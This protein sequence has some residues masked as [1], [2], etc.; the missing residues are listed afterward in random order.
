M[1]ARGASAFID[2]HDRRVVFFSVETI[3]N[4]SG[5]SWEALEYLGFTPYASVNERLA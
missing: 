5:V 2:W 4:I 1:C 3:G